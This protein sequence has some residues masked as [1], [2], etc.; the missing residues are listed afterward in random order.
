MTNELDVKTEELSKLS[1]LCKQQQDHIDD[2]SKK[3]NA[4]NNK[5]SLDNK[6]LID[7]ENELNNLKI[8]YVSK[9]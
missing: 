5:S 3:I 7:R 9:T 2:S 1:L 6:R 8:Q 4:L